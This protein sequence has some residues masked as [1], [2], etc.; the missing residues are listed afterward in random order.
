MESPEHIALSDGPFRLGIATMMMLLHSQEFTEELALQ[1]RRDGG[2]ERAIRALRR[3][4]L[5]EVHE[6]HETIVVPADAT[7]E[8]LIAWAK[9][10]FE[11]AGILFYFEDE[12]GASAL[13]QN[14]LE[15]VRGKRLGVLKR[16]FGRDWYISEGRKIQKMRGYDGNA[17]ALLVYC[18]TKK[19]DMILVSI[20]DTDDRFWSHPE[21]NIL[22]HALY[23]PTESTAEG[24]EFSTSCVDDGV[25]CTDYEFLLAFREV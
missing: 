2:P 21:S 3:E 12:L 9:E 16:A 4:F 22:F 8:S 19:P 15:L 13:V 10:E 20:P 24:Y 17:A 23:D 6:E 5:G 7:A 18:A 1:I 14:D 25:S 11:K